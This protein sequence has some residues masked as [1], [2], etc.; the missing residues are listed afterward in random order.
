[1]HIHRPPAEIELLMRAEDL[2]IGPVITWW[3]DKATWQGKKLPEKPLVQFDRDRF[4]HLLAGEDERE[5]GALLYFNLPEPLPIAGSKRETPSPVKFLEMARQ[6]PGVH[7]DVEKP[8]WWDMPVWVA[9]GKIDSMGLANN[10][11]QRDGML[12]NEAWG[13]PRETALFPSP[14]GNGRWSEHIYYQL[15]N[16]GFRIP[17]SAG[18]A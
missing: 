4:Y 13:K 16:G 6:T 10:H 11:D 5:G 18:S 7:I 3:N 8:F 1:L 14:Q 17:P 15:L 12:D 9:T 2:H